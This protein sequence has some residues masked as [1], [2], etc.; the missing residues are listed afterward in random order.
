[1]KIK[2]FAAL[3]KTILIVVFVLQVEALWASNQ[4]QIPPNII[5]IMADDLGYADLGSYGQKQIKT[6]NIDRFAKE[7]LQFTQCYSGSTVCAPSRSTLL[8]GMHTG[9]T[10]VRGNKSKSWGARLLGGKEMCH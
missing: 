8:T 1:M 7:G 10:T 3:I 4:S 2:I 6:P 9:H 5:F